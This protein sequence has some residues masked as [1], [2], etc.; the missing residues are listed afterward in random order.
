MKKS[1][2]LATLFITCFFNA[3]ASN[4]VDHSA[5]GGGSGGSG[6]TAST[7]EKA[8]LG[9]FMP[10]HLETV[11]PGAEFS[12]FA[13]NI[14]NPQQISVT[15]K[16]EPVAITSEFIDPYYLIKAKLPAALVNTAARI[17]IK[18]AAKSS[19]CE[20]EDGW[21]LKIADK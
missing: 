6:S 12:F 21:L 1:R 3:T 15:V 10:A 17:N 4:A 8:R 19:H 13:Y 7:C 14:D 11:M 20:A 2:L 9:K 18:V 5:H 16:T